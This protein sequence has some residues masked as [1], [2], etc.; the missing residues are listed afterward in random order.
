MAEEMSVLRPTPALIFSAGMETFEYN[1]RGIM[2][3]TVLG[4]CVSFVR[5]DKER[6][7]GCSNG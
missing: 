2:N 1:M 7:C 6:K 3:A 5:C 4:L